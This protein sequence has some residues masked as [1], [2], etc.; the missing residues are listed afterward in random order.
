MWYEKCYE[1]VFVNCSIR[2]V[3][4]L[5]FRSNRN[6]RNCF[7][8]WIWFT[9]SRINISFRAKLLF[10]FHLWYGTDNFSNSYFVTDLW[11]SILQISITC[12]W[13][14]FNRWVFDRW[15]ILVSF[16]IVSIFQWSSIKSFI[17]QEIRNG[18]QSRL[19]NSTCVFLQT[20]EY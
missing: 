11:T 14:K 6:S 2:V 20:I 17:V 9:I 8:H 10:K 5:R 3:L 15:Y 7:R 1:C 4:W 12:S 19:I 13:S 16:L 18:Y